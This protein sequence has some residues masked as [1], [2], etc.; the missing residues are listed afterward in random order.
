MDSVADGQTYTQ[1]HILDTIVSQLIRDSTKKGPV[2][3][4]FRILLSLTVSP[5][6][7]QF[8]IYIYTIDY[9]VHVVG[10]IIID[11]EVQSQ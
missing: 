3:S 1:T 6:V 11:S 4:R 2:I 7:F 8:Y 9:D 5:T 10:I